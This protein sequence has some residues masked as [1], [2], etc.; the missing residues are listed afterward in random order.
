MEDFSEINRN[1]N[2]KILSTP[3]FDKNVFGFKG[4]LISID[5]YIINIILN[6]KNEK[7]ETANFSLCNTEGEVLENLY[8]IESSSIGNINLNFNKKET[9]LNFLKSF[10]SEIIEEKYKTSNSIGLFKNKIEKKLNDIKEEIYKC[11]DINKFNLYERFLKKF[12]TDAIPEFLK[13]KYS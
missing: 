7:F 4:E 8:K 11:N 13:R 5:S 1:L 9:E 12:N 6:D 3:K 10:V 2:K